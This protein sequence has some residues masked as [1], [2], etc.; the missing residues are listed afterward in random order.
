MKVKMMMRRIVKWFN[1]D[2]GIKVVNTLLIVA[3]GLFMLGMSI[4][5]TIMTLEE[6]VIDVDWSFLL[7][8]VY[9][10]AGIIVIFSLGRSPRVAILVGGIAFAIVNMV[11]QLVI[12]TQIGSVP[13]AILSVIMD[14]AMVVS[15]IL[16]MTGDRHAPLRL[17]GICMIHF[18]TVFTA[19]MLEVLEVTDMFGYTTFWWMIIQ[20]IFL[21]I[22]MIL[23]L[24]PGIRE[25]TV[26]V[27]IRRGISVVSAKMVTGPSA[28]IGAKDVMALTGKDRS[29]WKDNGDAERIVSEYT[30]A[31]HEPERT[32]YLISYRWRDDDEVRIAIAPDIKY[33]PYG[34]GFVLRGSSVENRD[35]MRYLRLYGDEG[36]F[37]RLMIEEGEVDLVDEELGRTEPVEYLK[38][39]MITG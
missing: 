33:K 6:P 21:I 29:G 24:R 12:I 26:K 9:S 34:S 18:A 16:C 31:I 28:S 38:D 10:Y 7:M 8:T 4:A 39:K 25:E 13:S 1:S 32:T 20:C 14:V 5:G 36:F 19:Q 17:L 27:R 2:E 30:A 22:Y 11:M 3:L 23:L 15:A 35:G 37:I